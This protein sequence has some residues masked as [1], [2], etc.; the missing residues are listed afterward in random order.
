LCGALPLAVRLAAARMAL[1]TDWRVADLVRRLHD[2]VLP[3]LRAGDR[4]V[5]AAFSTSYLALPEPHRRLFRLLGVHPGERIDA[6]TAAA[7]AD[8]DATE[9]EDGLAA[10]HEV[11]LL[12]AVAHGA[13]RMHDLIREYA[14]S[15]AAEQP[16][17]HRAAALRL[18]DHAVHRTAA[19][20]WPVESPQT[21]LNRRFGEPLRPDLLPGPVTDPI[22]WFDQHHRDHMAVLRLAE[23]MGAH[24]HV[25]QL[26]RAAW[27]LWYLQFRFSEVVDAHQR[28]LRAA[29]S[30][31]DEPAAAVMANYLA[32]GLHRVGRAREAAAVLAEARKLPADQQR[33]LGIDCVLEANLAYTRLVIG[34]VAQAAA[35]AEAALRLAR[36]PGQSATLAQALNAIGAARSAQGRLAESL[37]WHR[38]ELFA[39][40][41]S[42]MSLSTRLN[43]L[44]NVAGIRMRLGHRPA[45]RMLVLSISL[46]RRIGNIMGLV[47]ASSALAVL[48]SRNGDLAA[49]TA[50]HREATTTA[51]R[52]SDFRLQA[53]VHNDFGETLAAAGEPEAAGEQFRLAHAL[54]R[55]A[56]ARDEEARSLEGL[57]R[58][59][60]DDAARREHLRQAL[61]IYRH[62]GVPAHVRRVEERLGPVTGAVAGR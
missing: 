26:A 59:A 27:R 57:G 11:H 43:A 34:D 41:M 60:T 14:A 40:S 5:A 52:Y 9:A 1:R 12:Q 53:V 25:W 42:A 62:I 30:I 6:A 48:H 47:E 28:G 29:R 49:A 36:R 50:L 18:F 46:S 35:S 13:Y 16:A 31:P 44:N 3:Q 45:E 2:R 38:H 32:S 4:A 23:A 37:R 8:V 24:R 39:T 22:R 7:L 17:E 33:A 55:R 58:S 61:T 54:A 56:E 51:R 10:L 15:L 20:S 19:V 21:R